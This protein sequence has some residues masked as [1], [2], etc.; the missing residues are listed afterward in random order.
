MQCN[1]LGNTCGCRCGQNTM[2]NQYQYFIIYPPSIE[3]IPFHLVPQFKK[4]ITNSTRI[5]CQKTSSALAL[6][7]QQLFQWRPSYLFTLQ[8]IDMMMMLKYHIPPL[9]IDFVALIGH[10]LEHLMIPAVSS[11][12]N[13]FALS[14]CLSV[15]LGRP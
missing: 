15:C 9:S 7:Q 3:K 6:C 13:L 10:L 11:I 1:K 8:F 2:T 12:F 14:Q 4:H 5:Y